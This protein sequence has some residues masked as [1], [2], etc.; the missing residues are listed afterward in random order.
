M[1]WGDACKCKRASGGTRPG[2]GRPKK[3]TWNSDC[4]DCGDFNYTD[5]N[6]ANVKKFGISSTKVARL[7]PRQA[8]S[9]SDKW[10]CLLCPANQLPHADS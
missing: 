6:S 2:A 4:C 8:A 9:Q 1:L 10:A 3:L 7:T 5:S